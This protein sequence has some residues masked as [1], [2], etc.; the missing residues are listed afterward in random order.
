MLLQ[1][2]VWAGHAAVVGEP[3]EALP[4]VGNSKPPVHAARHTEHPLGV[5]ITSS[6]PTPRT[7]DPGPHRPPS[8]PE[9]LL[10]AFVPVNSC[11]APGRH[12]RKT[13]R[14]EDV[15]RRHGKDNPPIRGRPTRRVWPRP[16]V[17]SFAVARVTEFCS[18]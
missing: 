2:C 3:Q 9:L 18:R 15:P 11:T 17:L 13:H 4:L 16:A 14:P 1:L 10:A 12:G 7:R 6:Y 5:R 8:E